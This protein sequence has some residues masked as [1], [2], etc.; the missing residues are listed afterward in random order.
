MENLLHAWRQADWKEFAGKKRRDAAAKLQT[1]PENNDEDGERPCGLRRISAEPKQ[2][3][4][5]QGPGQARRQR[6]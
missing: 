2:K 4:G 5:D 6:Q 3:D 1:E